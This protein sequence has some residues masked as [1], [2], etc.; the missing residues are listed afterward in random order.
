M[1]STTTSISAASG[2]R[3]DWDAMTDPV[4]RFAESCGYVLAVVVR[5]KRES[6]FA[7]YVLSGED[8]ISQPNF[9]IRQ[10]ELTVE[11]FHVLEAKRPR[12]AL[13]TTG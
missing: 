13:P 5:P 9:R 7:A 2:F 12:F 4:I 3:L 10:V 8:W 11:R 1:V 6:G